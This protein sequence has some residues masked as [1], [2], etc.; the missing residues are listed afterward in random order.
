MF[1][2]ITRNNKYKFCPTAKKDINVIESTETEKGKVINE[3]LS[4]RG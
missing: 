3:R 1:V 2:F 4:L